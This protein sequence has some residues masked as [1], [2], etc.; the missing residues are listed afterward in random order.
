MKFYLELEKSLASVPGLSWLR[1]EAWHL[2]VPEDLDAEGITTED[3]DRLSVAYGLSRVDI[4]N[5][6]KALPCPSCEK[7][8]VEH[9]VTTM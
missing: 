2:G 1:A 5:L 8:Q 6:R 9:G 4:G 3:F 7:R